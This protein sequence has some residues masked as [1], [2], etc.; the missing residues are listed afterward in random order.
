MTPTLPAPPGDFFFSRFASSL[1]AQPCAG[2]NSEGSCG[3][4]WFKSIYAV[5]EN[6]EADVEEPI[7]SADEEEDEYEAIVED[8]D[9]GGD[10][11]TAR[12]RLS[13]DE[14]RDLEQDDDEL[15]QDDEE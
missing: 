5:D 4:N 8:D 3:G 15:E 6:P 13:I 10:D 7:D 1:R 9:D 11:D 14:V 12:A 2:P